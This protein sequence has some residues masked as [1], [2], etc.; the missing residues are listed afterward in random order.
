MLQAHISSFQCVVSLDPRCE[1]GAS[2]EVYGDFENRQGRSTLC[3]GPDFP[4]ARLV[5]KSMVVYN[6]SR[7]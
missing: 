1:G 2:D 5:I 3:R 6:A 4:G 7:V